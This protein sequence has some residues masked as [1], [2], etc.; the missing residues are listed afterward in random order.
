MSQTFRHTTSLHRILGSKNQGY[1]TSSKL[2]PELLTTVQLHAMYV[3][4]Q[5]CGVC[6]WTSDEDYIRSGDANINRWQ[7]LNGHFGPYN[8][9]R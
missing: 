4:F 8:P 5:T 2:R 3:A 1:N 7:P 9:N 6:A